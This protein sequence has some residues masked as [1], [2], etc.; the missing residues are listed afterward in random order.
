MM[1]NCQIAQI[2]TTINKYIKIKLTNWLKSLQQYDEYGL[3]LVVLQRF[4][5]L[6]N[7]N[8]TNPVKR[9][10]DKQNSLVKQT[11]PFNKVHEVRCVYLVHDFDKNKLLDEGSWNYGHQKGLPLRGLHGTDL[12][13]I[14]KKHIQL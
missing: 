14:K 7:E 13:Y 12:F 9:I 6:K 3:V 5:T 4:S 10:N 1:H 2:Q 8:T 11:A